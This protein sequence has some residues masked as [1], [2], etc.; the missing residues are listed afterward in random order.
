M[1]LFDSIG[2]ALFGDG[3]AK[4]QRRALQ[5]STQQAIA[6]QREF[7]GKAGPLAQPYQRT[8]AVRRWPAVCFAEGHAFAF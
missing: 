6:A 2:K 3:G 8:R 4:K 1:G 7:F 5:Q